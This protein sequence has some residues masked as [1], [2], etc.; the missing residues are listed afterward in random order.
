MAETAVPYLTSPDQQTW[1]DKLNVEYD[2][3]RVALNWSV[4]T[5][6]TETAVRLGAALGRY[7][8]L[9]Y[10]PKEGGNWLRQI[11]ALPGPQTV[12]RARAMSYAGMLARLRRDYQEAETYLSTCIDIQQQSGSELDLGRS[13]NELGMVYLDQGESSR[14]QPLFEAWLTLAAIWTLL[15]AFLSPCSTWAW[16]CSN[17]ANLIRQRLTIKRV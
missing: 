16:L 6:Q 15:M 14:A 4:E 8:W 13:L 11:L 1:L 3:L 10:R 17:K 5:Q 12:L 2:N 7:W 9:R